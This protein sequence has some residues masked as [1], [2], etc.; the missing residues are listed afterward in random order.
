MLR[1]DLPPNLGRTI[2]RIQTNP[3]LD[4]MP[5]DVLSG[6]PTITQDKT[7]I[8]H[9]EKNIEI[10]KVS[11]RW[12]IQYFRTWLYIFLIYFFYAVFQLI[13]FI[14]SSRLTTS[15]FK[16]SVLEP[17]S[18]YADFPQKGFILYIQRQNQISKSAISE[19]YLSITLNNKSPKLI[20]LL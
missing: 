11:G 2:Q 18:Q 16:Q 7:I 5:S 17:L 9:S 19:Y 14:F 1:V 12:N 3:N 6:L 8:M 13:K 4:S 10:M 15:A 20:S